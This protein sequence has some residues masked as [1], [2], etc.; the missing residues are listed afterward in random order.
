MPMR[1]G[2]KHS[3]TDQLIGACVRSVP[4]RNGNVTVPVKSNANNFRFVA[5]L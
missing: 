2:N 1:N 4:M 3:D 5:C